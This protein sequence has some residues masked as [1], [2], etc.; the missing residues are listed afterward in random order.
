MNLPIVNGAQT[1]ADTLRH[2]FFHYVDGIV[3]RGGLPIAGAADEMA[4]FRA[5]GPVMPPSAPDWE[6]HAAYTRA[7]DTTRTKKTYFGE[8]HPAKPGVT[9]PTQYNSAVYPLFGGG[10][11]MVTQNAERYFA[12]R[13]FHAECTRRGLTSR[14]FDAWAYADKPEGLDA[15]WSAS[16]TWS[17]ADPLQPFTRERIERYSDW[18]QKARGAYG[19]E[20]FHWYD[21]FTTPEG[22]WK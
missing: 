1:A 8:R 21:Q 10:R 12:M 11:E 6:P 7:Y 2:E 4:P 15:L 14:D 13:D 22:R 19:D 20:L 16:E 18:W 9:V 3:S 5:T 17:K